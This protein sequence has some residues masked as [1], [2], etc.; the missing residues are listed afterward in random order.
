MNSFPLRRSFL[1]IFFAVHLFGL[2][3]TGFASM[4]NVAIRDFVFSPTSVT[5]NL[6]DRVRWVWTGAAPHSTTSDTGLWDSGINDTGSTFT[7]TFSGEGDFPYHCRVHGSMRAAV[8]VLGGDTPPIISTQP[9]SRTVAAGTNVTFNVIAS[10]I[11]PLG[12]QWRFNSDPIADAT[13]SSLTLNNVQFANAGTYSVVLSNSLGVT[14]SSDAVLTVT[15]LKG[16]YYGLFFDPANLSV[17]NAGTFTLSTTAAGKF[18]AKLQSGKNKL[19]LSGQFDVGGNASNSI[20]RSGQSPLSVLF[21]LGQ[22]DID[23]ITGSVSDGISVVPLAGNRSVFDGRQQLAPQAGQYTMIISG[24]SGSDLL[25]G[26]DGFATVAVDKSAKIKVTGS[27]SDNT[28]FSQSVPLSKHGDWPLGIPLYGNLGLIIG[29]LNISNGITGDVAW[30]K[31][32][33][34]TAKFYPAGFNLATT[35]TGLPYHPPAAGTGL[36]SLSNEMV[37]LS[38]GGLADNIT[39]NITVDTKSKVTNLSSNRLSLTFK[40]TTGA[41]SGKVAVPNSTQSLPIG[42]VLL[43]GA[44]SAQGY[45]LGTGQSGEVLVTH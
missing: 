32:N 7:N 8:H 11:Q 19:S 12:Y 9:Q 22:T 42:G 38:D 43:Q 25:P 16:A 45:F 34:P 31:P 5:V 36:F 24:V 1:P 3:Q 23:E 29:W 33:L 15:P 4:T 39:N 26:G 27:L 6:N 44:D 30:L 40:V 37:L 13:D 17:Q 21:H 2:V 20:V 18:T 41:F 10:G 35:A 28:K 14:P